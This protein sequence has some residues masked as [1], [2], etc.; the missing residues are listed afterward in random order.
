MAPPTDARKTGFSD[1]DLGQ[2]AEAVKDAVAP[3]PPTRDELR[4]LERR[5]SA[6]EEHRH[7]TT[8]IE[9]RQRIAL[10]QLNA[11]VRDVAGLK[12]EHEKL[13]ARQSELDEKQRTRIV[14]LHRVMY[15]YKRKLWMPIAL[16]F[17]SGTG[18]GYMLA[19]PEIGGR[20]LGKILETIGKMIAGG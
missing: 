19:I 17:G 5:V 11:V 10:R 4:S 20:V 12:D 6:I 13:L 18:A 2:I 8:R 9:E 3:A 14:R 1:S 15:G 16:L 7:S